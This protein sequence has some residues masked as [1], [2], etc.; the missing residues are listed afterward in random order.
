[1]FL[2]SYQPNPFFMLTLRFW[3]YALSA[4]CVMIS[5]QSCVRDNCKNQE[6][7]YMAYTPVY[8]SQS[9]LEG[10]VQV[11]APRDLVN[12][13]K[14]YTYQDYLIINELGQGVHII[15][16]SNPAAPQNLAFLVTPGSYDM[17]ISC[18]KLYLDSSTDLVV[19]DF[20][21]PVRP[22]VLSRVP[23]TFPHKTT[24]NGFVADP[25][26]GKVIAWEKEVITEEY[27]CAATLPVGVTQN[28]WGGTADEAVAFNSQ[29]TA[30]RTASPSQSGVAGSLARF[31]T[32]GDYFYV[33]TDQSLQVYSLQDCSQP[34]RIQEVFLDLWGGAAETIFPKDDRL[35]IGSTSGMFMYDIGSDPASPNFLGSIQHATACDPVV[36]EGNYAYVT[37]RSTGAEGP[38][39]G[40]NNQ[41][42][43]INIEDPTFPFVESIIPMTGPQG[44][45]V[46]GN[47]LFV[48]DGTSG[49]RVMDISAPT[50]AREVARFTQM[51]ATDVIALADK[52]IM[53]GDDGLVQYSYDA[54]LNMQLLSTI[55]VVR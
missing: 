24:F 15:D 5:M 54:G 53:I 32:V 49:M 41:L 19:F 34:N 55:P 46:V 51:Q 14:I 42:D 40:F 8:M 27:D 36:A 18:G 26:L 35:Y 6:I 11:D 4:L 22:V 2:F 44:L 23:N 30:S 31:A 38:C 43:V 33:I 37:L 13:G 39:P 3:G 9:E 21:N 48:C 7:T 47:R 10:A 50:D 45:G 1:M 29:S 12:P 25:S 28:P 17:A 20:Q 16:N 52:L